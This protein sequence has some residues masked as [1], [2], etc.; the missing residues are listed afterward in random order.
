MSIDFPLISMSYNMILIHNYIIFSYFIYRGNFFDN[1]A[2][3]LHKY[4]GI[5]FF[6]IATHQRRIKTSVQKFNRKSQKIFLSLSVIELSCI[7][8]YIKIY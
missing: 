4:K 5:I 8:H 7:I 6:H 1:I 2:I 3:K